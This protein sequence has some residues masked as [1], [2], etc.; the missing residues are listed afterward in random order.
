MPK[1]T[2]S[3]PPDRTACANCHGTGQGPLFA[4]ADFNAA[5]PAA[6]LLL[7]GK[8]SRLQVKAG[9]RHCG[10]NCNDGAAMGQ[11]VAAYVA[12]MSAAPTPCPPDAPAAPP[13]APPVAPPPPPVVPATAEARGKIVYDTYCMGC[14]RLG[15]Y[16]AAGSPNLSGKENAVP[17]EYTA[18]VR[19]HKSI[20]L[21]AAQISDLRAFITVY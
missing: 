11:A 17:G 6:Q 16:D 18:D 7:N 20:T 5:Y 12:A 21:S 2:K 13:A 15:T 1:Y 8:P 3:R 10:N 14:H 9:D 4:I 19:G